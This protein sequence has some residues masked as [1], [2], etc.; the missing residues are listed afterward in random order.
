MI[1]VDLDRLWKYIRC[2][3]SKNSTID[4]EESDDHDEDSIVHTYS[5]EQQ[6]IQ[7]LIAMSNLHLVVLRLR[8]NHKSMD[9]KFKKQE[10]RNQIFE[11]QFED[12]SDFEDL[13]VFENQL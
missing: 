5:H 4:S 8:N 9:V 2:R 11:K 3:K 13:D 7:N 12:E 1:N 10:L 6:E